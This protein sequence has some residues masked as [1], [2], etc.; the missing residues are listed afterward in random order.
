ML[1]PQTTREK[2]N[3]VKKELRGH[4]ISLPA[5]PC[6]LPFLGSHSLQLRKKGRERERKTIPASTPSFSA[7]ANCIDRGDI[8]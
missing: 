6:I 1:N 3:V 5:N 4:A 8:G 2:E 7:N